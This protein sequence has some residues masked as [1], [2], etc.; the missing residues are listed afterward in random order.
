[1]SDSPESDR[2][3]IQG[4]FVRLH[5]ASDYEG[6]AAIA[7]RGYGTEL[8]RHLQRVLCDDG[9]A[10]DAFSLTAEWIWRGVKDFRQ[11]SSLRTWLYKLAQHACSRIF[12]DKHRKRRAPLDTAALAGLVAEVRDST[13]AYRKTEVKDAVREIRTKLPEL[14]RALL[15]LRVDQGLS[16]RDIADVLSSE[17]EALSEATVRKRFERAKSRLRELA[18]EAGLA[19]RR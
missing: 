8:A 7:L 17:D 5:A 15:A 12:R 6:A 9:A 1:M 3:S 14:D 18:I 4:E 11:E 19:A 16:W 2:A 10:D 13:A